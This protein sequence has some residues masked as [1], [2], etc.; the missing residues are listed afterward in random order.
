M[1]F[2]KINLRTE[3]IR[4]RQAQED[5][6]IEARRL[7]QE[8]DSK[9]ADMRI[10]LQGSPTGSS[11]LISP[12]EEDMHRIFHLNEIKNL[13]VRFR[14]RFL[15]TMYFKSEYPFEALSE[16]RDF[17]RR[18]KTKIKEFYIAAPDHSFDLEN[19]NKDPLLFASLGEDKYFLLHQ[20]GN[21]LAWYK[22]LTL[23]PL[24]SFKNCFISLWIA[25][26]LFSFI[27]PSS[28]IQVTSFE[29]EMYLRLWLTVHVFIAFFGFT[30]WAGLT[31]D[32]TVSNKNWN[33]K[34]Y[35]G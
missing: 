5:L 21:D 18:Y 19:I 34:Y 14:L 30:V 10:R 27:I 32:K 23:W 31:F 28:I 12:V 22:K 15:N 1:L 35:N 13:C 16:I 8:F 7:L 2:S 6:L 4:E 11:S 29:G 17:E 25:A 26:L 20:W 3:L 24:R 9:E 33:S